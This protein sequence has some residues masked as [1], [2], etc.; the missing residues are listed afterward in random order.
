MKQHSAKD[1]KLIGISKLSVVCD[2]GSLMSLLHC[3]RSTSAEQLS[4]QCVDDPMALNAVIVFG[5]QEFPMPQLLQVEDNHEGN[6]GEDLI[7]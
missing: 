4:A 3:L 5:D 2:C 6:N 7:N 1:G